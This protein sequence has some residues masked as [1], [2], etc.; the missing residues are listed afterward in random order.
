MHIVLQVETEQTQRAWRCGGS[1]ASGPCDAASCSRD[2]MPVVLWT[3]EYLRPKKV[4]FRRCR[5]KGQT[6]CRPARQDVIL[7]HHQGAQSPS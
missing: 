2:S 7:S 3:L 4:A 1:G 6:A 5:A